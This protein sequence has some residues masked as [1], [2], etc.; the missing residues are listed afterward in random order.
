MWSKNSAIRVPSAR[1]FRGVRRLRNV[2]L[3]N[4]SV[5]LDEY[6]RQGDL[7]VNIFLIKHKNMY[8]Y[9]DRCIV[10]NKK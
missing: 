6:S 4:R 9:I 8:S 5:G 3:C 10:L 2:N 1:V 7:N